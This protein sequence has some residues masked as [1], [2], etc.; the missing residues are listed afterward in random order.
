MTCCMQVQDT[1]DKENFAMGFPVPPLI[2]FVGEEKAHLSNANGGPRVFFN[3]EDHQ[4][5]QTG[6]PNTMFEVSDGYI[7]FWHSCN[8]CN[9][10]C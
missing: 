9:I 10:W 8:N 3:I 4:S 7:P 2:R 1:M 5:Y 6:R